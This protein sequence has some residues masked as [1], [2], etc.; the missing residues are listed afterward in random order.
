M[1]HFAQTL[2][3]VDDPERIAEYI[4]HHA[5]VWPEVVQGLRDIGIRRLRIFLHGNRLFMY[6]EAEDDF[7]PVRDY[8]RYATDPRTHAWDQLMRTYQRRVPAADPADGAWWSAMREVF[9]LESAA[10]T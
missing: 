1:R 10:S 4:A 6:V 9:D 8:G 5:A 2:E 7:D 3:L